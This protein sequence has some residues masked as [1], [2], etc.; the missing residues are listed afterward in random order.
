LPLAGIAAAEEPAGNSPEAE[1]FVS[2]QPTA[3]LPATPAEST[4]TVEGPVERPRQTDLLSTEKPEPVDLRLKVE[5]VTEYFPDRTVKIERYVAR[6]EN[7]NYFN[8]GTWIEWNHDAA[9][10]GR[11]KYRY[12]QRHGTWIRWFEAGEGPMFADTVF[13]P[14]QPPFLCEATFAEGKLQGVWTIR[15][16][17]ERKVCQWNFDQGE[18]HGKSTWYFPSGHRRKEVDFRRGQID[19]QSLEWTLERPAADRCQRASTTE[20]VHTLLSRV[21]YENGHRHDTHVEWYSPGKK[22]VE[23]IYLSAQPEAVSQHD[24]WNGSVKTTAVGE[25]GK[26]QRHGLWTGWYP[27]G[28]R[29]WQGEFRHD[30]P[31]GQ[32]VWFHPNGQKK[33]EGHFVDGLESGRWTWWHAS[34]QKHLQG[35]YEEGE[36]MGEWT[37]WDDE[38]KVIEVQRFNVEGPQP[39]R[40]AE[41]RLPHSPAEPF[42][43]TQHARPRGAGHEG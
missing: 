14:F 29:Q 36:P 42:K 39:F 19:G 30:E 2:D 38:G 27:H 22:K 43:T 25:P 37:R 9:L 32:H 40:P 20:P 41:T 1:V 17:L 18:L 34:G 11:G 5:L 26:Q 35:S 23:G 21:K 33:V 16:A 6:D 31:V 24:W 10:V 4:A 13:Q 7:D 3:E 8:H 28:G 12:G 15:D